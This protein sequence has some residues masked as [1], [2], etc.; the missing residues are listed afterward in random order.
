VILGIT[1]APELRAQA[2]SVPKFEVASVRRSPPLQLPLVAPFRAGMFLDEGRIEF[3]L[4]S[5][6]DLILIAYRIKQFQ[7]TG[8]PDWFAIDVFDIVAT[9]PQ[10][11]S[12]T[13]VPEMQCASD[14]RPCSV[15]TTKVP[16]MLQALLA[17]RFGLKIRRENKEM[18]VYV[19]VV[20]KD[21]PKF[22]ESPPDDPQAEPVFPKP[23]EGGIVAGV[24]G[25]V[26]GAPARIGPA[27]GRG[28]V[29]DPGKWAAAGLLHMEIPKAT[30]GL[31]ADTLTSMLDRPVVDRTELTGK[32]EIGFDVPWQ[33]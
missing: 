7:L 11:V 22:K 33:D 2:Q 28:S 31:L 18:P 12:T 15:S 21:G 14:E 16:E 30:M 5:L 13:K 27:G 10:G 29:S 8:G 32:Y 19:L 20:S 4:M 25:A 26:D 23:P 1:N 24:G 9:I 3:K 17:D 6:R